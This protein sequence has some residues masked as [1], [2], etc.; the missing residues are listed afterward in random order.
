MV[1]TKANVIVISSGKGGVGKTVTA[2]NLAS[3]LN[4]L[5]K[6]TLLID[7]NLTTPNIGINLGAPSV[8]ITLNH[9]LQEKN[10]IHEAI[11]KHH[12]GTKIILASFSI[13]D[14]QGIKPQK[15]NLAISSLK[16]NFDFIIIDSAAGLGREALLAFPVADEILIITNP[17]N[18]AVAD[19]LKTLHIAKKFNKKCSII[20]NK[21]RNDKKELSE[22]AIKNL[23]ET[24]I[25]ETIPEDDS[26]KESLMIR[27]AII[28]THPKSK[29][30]KAYES[31]AKKFIEREESENAEDEKSE[32]DEEEQD[33][34]NI[35]E[36][37]SFFSKIFKKS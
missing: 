22:E 15:F 5:G 37:K 33:K 17:E 21:T 2:I 10:T 35:D 29:A 8:P 14:L 27:D 25:L 16:A 23:L 31:L 12:S 20:L 9:V 28:H 24:E 11:Y 18:A 19:A 7:S 34:E 6:K 13:Q 4:K 30:T 1:K 26:I 3:A 36:K 32:E